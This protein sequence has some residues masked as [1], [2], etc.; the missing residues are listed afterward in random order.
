MSNKY[1]YFYDLNEVLIDRYPTIP[2]GS[3]S[4]FIKKLSRKE[5]VKITTKYPPNSITTIAQRIPDMWMLTFFNHI[6]VPTYIVQ[7]G[8]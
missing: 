2:E 1:F 6:S 4:F 7:H 8:L 3:K 5:L